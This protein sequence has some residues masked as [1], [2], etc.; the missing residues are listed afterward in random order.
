MTQSTQWCAVTGTGGYLGSLVKAELA[1]RGWKVGEFSRQSAVP[2]QLGTEV[3]RERLAGAKALVHCAYD[4][5]VLSWEDIRRVNIAGT[6]KVLR[7][8]REARVESLIYIS[9][10]SAFEGCRSLYGKAKLEAEAVA[11][12]FGAVVLR[13]GLIW[14]EPAGAMFAR[15]KTQVKNARVLPLFGGGRQIQ[16]LVHS[17]DLTKAIGGFVEG[18][19]PKP[20]R[21]VT[22]ANEQ[23]WA[24]R[25]ILDELARALG[26]KVIYVPAPWRLLWCGIKCAEMCGMRLNFRS[27]SL[28]SL[29]YQNPKPSF[30]EQRELG[31]VC[32]PFS[33]ERVS[34]EKFQADPGR[35]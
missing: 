28:L 20:E 33:C 27:D 22:I 9:S 26:K 11:R 7:A 1:E 13:P 2:F 24:F 21:P 35:S 3:S 6:E 19:I 15:L 18:R 29:M 14:G 4:F 5:K 25:Q 30:A 10:I 34:A 12:S 16:Y 17:Q 23:P 31:I 8:A 32:R